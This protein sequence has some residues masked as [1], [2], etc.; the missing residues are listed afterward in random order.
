LNFASADWPKRYTLWAGVAGK[1]EPSRAMMRASGDNAGVK[2]KGRGWV[3]VLFAGHPS[4]D[5]DRSPQRRHFM[6]QKESEHCFC[7]RPS[8]EE[9]S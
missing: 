5:P 1:L 7:F 2:T 3:P 8:P 9:T 4:I 6:F